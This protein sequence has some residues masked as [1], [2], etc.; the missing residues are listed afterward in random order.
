MQLSNEDIEYIKDNYDELVNI[1]LGKTI[2]STEMK[3]W[4]SHIDKSVC[5]ICNRKIQVLV[6]NII[7]V[8]NKRK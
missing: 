4:L 5:L 3:E 8:Y 6:G 1:R 7:Y 2:P